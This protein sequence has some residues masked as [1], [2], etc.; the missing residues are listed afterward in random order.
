MDSGTKRLTQQEL[1]TKTVK[2]LLVIAKGFKIK[3]RHALSKQEII[4]HIVDVENAEAPRVADCI[5][6]SDDKK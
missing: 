6:M 4:Q 2:E 5:L 1:R 3:G